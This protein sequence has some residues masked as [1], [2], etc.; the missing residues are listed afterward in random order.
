M[1]TPSPYILTVIFMARITLVRNIIYCKK[2]IFQTDLAHSVVFNKQ[3][4]TSF[5]LMTEWLNIL[6]PCYVLSMFSYF[7]VNCVFNII[8]YFSYLNLWLVILFL[9]IMVFFLIVG[10]T[11]LINSSRL[12]SDVIFEVSLVLFSFFL[13]GIIISPALII[14]LDLELIIMPSFI[15][16]S[17]GMQWQ[18]SFTISYQNWL[19]YSDH[20]VMQSFYWVFSG[21]S[22]T[23]STIL[24]VQLEEV[25]RI[26]YAHFYL[27]V[28][29]YCWTYYFIRHYI[30]LPAL[31]YIN[32]HYSNNCRS[33]RTSFNETSNISLKDYRSRMNYYWIDY[34]DFLYTI[35]KSLLYMFDTNELILLP[36]LS[37]IR[38]YVFSYD[39]IHSL[40]IYSFGIKIDSIPGRFNFTST[41]RTL[42]KGEHRGMCY[43]LCGQ[44]HSSMLIIGSVIS[45]VFIRCAQ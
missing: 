2:S 41:I 13:I 8:E 37:T 23:S 36:L 5:Y 26:D 10:S 32:N 15:I 9:F 27:V 21:G 42:I 24:P 3:S 28:L 18:W 29:N 39:V 45:P 22:R 44:G 6:L 4:F 17:T 35:T 30:I 19:S 33:S 43:E 11:Q 16:Y 1:S 38:Y 7:S 14:L 12:C 25:D 34:H 20:H 40:G 31:R